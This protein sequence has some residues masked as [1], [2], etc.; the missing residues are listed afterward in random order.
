MSNMKNNIKSIILVCLF[1]LVVCSCSENRDEDSFVAS[2]RQ[3]QAVD[4][5]RTLLVSE[6]NGWQLVYFPKVNN[7]LNS[8]VTENIKNT[9]LFKNIF[10][11]QDRLGV[12][13]YNVFIKFNKDG[14]CQMFSDIPL[15]PSN[16]NEKLDPVYSFDVSNSAYQLFIGDDLSIRFTNDS[17]IERL[18]EELINANVTFEIDSINIQTKEIRLKTNSYEKSNMEYIVMRPLEYRFDEIPT[19]LE[20]IK[21]NAE[22]YR[23]RMYQSPT[24]N[25]K[26]NRNCVM[27]ISVKSTGVEVYRSTESFGGNLI[28][29]RISMQDERGRDNR[30]I[31]LIHKYDVRR[32]TLFIKNE[33]PEK[34]ISDIDNSQYYTALGSG[35]VPTEDGLMFYPGFNYLGIAKFSHFEKISDKEWKSE[36]GPYEAK[37]MFVE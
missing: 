34:T 28:S 36:D 18:Y 37:I 29:Q 17:P 6:N 13:G 19:K 3:Q 31:N 1:S 11:L 16:D 5:L 15:R 8:D 32:Y 14:R 35:Y 2:F 25:T 10:F 21:Q 20:T 4:N 9:I 33:E 26:D 22:V 30:T 24:L 27:S 23:R 7:K 12:G